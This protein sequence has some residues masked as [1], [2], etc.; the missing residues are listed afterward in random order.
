MRIFNANRALAFQ[1]HAPSLHAGDDLQIGPL[2]HVGGEISLGGGEALPI[3]DGR[4]ILANAFELRPV[5]IVGQLVAGL[6]CRFGKGCVERIGQGALA[7]GVQRA[8][9][10][11]KFVAAA[12]RILGLAEIGQYIGPAPPGEAQLAPAV[13]IAGVAAD[14]HHAVDRR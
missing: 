12:F 13:I 2:A 6:H 4:V 7:A 8:A 5:E 10:P 9:A 1:Q 14:I 11:V 3:L